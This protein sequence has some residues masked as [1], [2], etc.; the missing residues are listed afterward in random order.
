M[1]FVTS[2]FAQLIGRKKLT[3]YKYIFLFDLNTVFIYLHLTLTVAVRTFQWNDIQ[4]IGKT[5]VFL[6]IQKPMEMS[7]NAYKRTLDSYRNNYM[8][9]IIVNWRKNVKNGRIK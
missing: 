4:I 6:L 5:I 1:G 8:C 2:Y 3:Y 7:R 9:V